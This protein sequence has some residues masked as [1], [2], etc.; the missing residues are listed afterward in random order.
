MR[1]ALAEMSGALVEALVAEL[2]GA[3]VADLLRQEPGLVLQSQTRRIKWMIPKDNV[4]SETR[5]SRSLRNGAGGTVFVK[6]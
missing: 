3:L 5:H 1:G 6:S 4:F 2:S